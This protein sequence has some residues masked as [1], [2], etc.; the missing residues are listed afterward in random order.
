VVAA[1]GIPFALELQDGVP[2]LHKKAWKV[3]GIDTV[4]PKLPVG[5]PPPPTDKPEIG[6]LIGLVDELAEMDPN[7][8]LPGETKPGAP[9]AAVPAAT[10]PAGTKPAPAGGQRP[11]GNTPPW[12]HP[13]KS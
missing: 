8:M 6:D 9:A 13:G 7:A 12:K 10:T 1:N 11:A 4:K 3:Q 5:A 2:A